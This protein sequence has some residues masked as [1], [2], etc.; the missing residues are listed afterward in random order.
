MYLKRLLSVFIAVVLAIPTFTIA[1]A[2]S[3]ARYVGS[4]SCSECHET[5]YSNFKNYAKKAT[6]W[7]SIEVMASD[8]TSDEL[9]GC[10]SCHT[11]GYGQPGGFVSYDKT[12]ELSDAGC[13]VCHGP[14]SEHIDSGGDPDLIKGSLDIQSCS[15]CHNKERVA[16]FDFKPMLYGGAH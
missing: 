16:A 7:K 3:S 4:K 6:S 8:L 2:Q 11:T 5:E 14:G 13:E 15:T 12:P 10:Y 1:T 9:K